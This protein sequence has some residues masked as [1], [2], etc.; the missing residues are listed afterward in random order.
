MKKTLSLILF[1]FIT[2]GFAPAALQT[3][4][5][6]TYGGSDYKLIYDD[7]TQLTWLD[8][9]IPATGAYA[10]ALAWAEGLND[11]GVVTVTLDAGYSASWGAS[12]WRLPESEGNYGYFGSEQYITSTE[13][14]HVYYDE[15]GNI[16]NDPSVDTGLFDYI[17]VNTQSS[18]YYYTKP[19]FSTVTYI[20]AFN[21]YN[22][23]QVFV[24][25]SVNGGI[26]A[27]AVIEGAV[28]PEPATLGLLALGGLA[29][30]RKRK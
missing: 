1:V 8:Y 19:N 15:L 14:E 22:G 3:I 2:A 9:S 10:G 17:V 23:T 26:Y 29:L 13:F 28:V 4:G 16:L 11:P 24:T 6:A 30:L 5:T 21:F 25:N 27:M 20:P 18:S 12:Q 7:H